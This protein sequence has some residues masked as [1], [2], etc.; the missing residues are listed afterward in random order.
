MATVESRNLGLPK[1]F[2]D[3][4]DC[5]IDESDVRVRIPIAKVPHPAVVVGLQILDSVRAG[6]YV[7]EQC[8]EHSRAQALMHQIIDF[9]QHWRGND[10][11]LG[12]IFDQFPGSSMVGI[13]PIQGCV[14]RSRI[15]H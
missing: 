1:T 12:S 5:G 7:V 3:R 8:D 11:G 9:N 4:N 2:D 6:G 10:E 15:E 14:E 13:V